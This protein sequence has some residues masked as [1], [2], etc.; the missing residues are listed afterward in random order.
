MIGFFV[1]C[2]AG[3]GILL[4]IV[5]IIILKILSMFGIIKILIWH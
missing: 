2:L 4:I 3:G 1:E 5:E